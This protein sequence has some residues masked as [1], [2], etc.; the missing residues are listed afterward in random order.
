[1]RVTADG[2]QILESTFAAG[3]SF[4]ISAAKTITVRPG[5][6]PGLKLRVWGIDVPLP[7]TRDPYTFEIKLAEQ[8]SKAVEKLQREAGQLEKIIKAL[9]K[10]QG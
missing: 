7:E 6:P 2:R 1:V 4:E 8:M 10:N 9:Q 3:Q 5:N